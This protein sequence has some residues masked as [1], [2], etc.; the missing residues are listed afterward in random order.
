MAVTLLL[1]SFV[2]YVALGRAGDRV[3]GSAGD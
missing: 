3:R 1:V 2:N